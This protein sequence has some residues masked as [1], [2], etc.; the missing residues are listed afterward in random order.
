MCAYH[1]HSSSPSLSE[2]NSPR[3]LPTSYPSITRVLCTSMIPYYFIHPVIPFLLLLLLLLPHPLSFF[4]FSN[5]SHSPPST[6]FPT[7]TRAVFVQSSAKRTQKP[8][9]EAVQLFL[10]YTSTTTTNILA[11]A[12]PEAVIRNH[13]RKE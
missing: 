5:H 11:A 13:P 10:R 6:I 9:H 4:Q 3:H 1:N 8:R 7:L 2:Y 12:T